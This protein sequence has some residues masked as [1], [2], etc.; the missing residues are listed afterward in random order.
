MK[1]YA[2][3]FFVIAGALYLTGCD[4]LASLGFPKSKPKAKISSKS[5]EIPAGAIVVAKVGDLYITS[6]DLNKE[7]EN[8]N[9][10]L[11]A[12]GLTQNK[13]DSREKKI[14]YLKNEMVRKYALYQEAL[15]RGIE[16]KEAVA[17]DIKNAKI[18]ILVAE[19]LRGEMEKIDVSNA[20]VEDFYN[21]NKDL[22]KEPEQR[23]IL[24]IVTNNEDE[25]KQA[26]IEIL[27][28]TDFASLA[29]QYSK[30]ATASKGGDLGFIT[31]DPDPKKRIR[32]DKFYEVAFSPNLD[33][34]GI[35]NIFKGPD[36]YY[37]VKV[38]SVKKSEAKTLAEL[39]ENIKSWLLFDKQQKSIMELANKL[40]GGT[41]IE[42]F[43]GKVD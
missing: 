16:R 43:E 7:I 25:A 2:V 4:Q 8:Y 17:R 28:G 27:K 15:D 5:E 32:S 38:E 41:R 26:Y 12:Q 22:L 33:A 29:K 9:A 19:L 24:E 14:N 31:I 36:G 18:S 34:G 23:R 6:E 39:R 3:L 40:T 37:I 11:S 30:A 42:I 10:L 35:S 1:K 20:D 13:I 21:K